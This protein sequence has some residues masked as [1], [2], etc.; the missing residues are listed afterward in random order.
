MKIRVKQGRLSVTTA[1]ENRVVLDE[2]KFL[3]IA[4]GQDNDVDKDSMFMANLSFADPVYDKAS[5]SYDSDILSEVYDHDNYRDAVCEHHEVHE[6]HDDVQPNCIVDSD[7]EYTGDINMIMYDQYVKDNAELVVK[8]NVS[9]VP[10]DAYM[11]IINE[12]H[13]HTAHCISVKAQNKVDDAS[14]TAELATY[15]EQVKLYKR[16]AKFELIKREQKI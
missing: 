11:M 4:G 8:N 10:N 2:E 5:Q 1:M 9:S 16:R 14:L 13:E 15:K 12:M 6:M 7:V 3:F